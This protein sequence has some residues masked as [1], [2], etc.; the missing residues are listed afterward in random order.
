MRIAAALALLFIV[1]PIARA[2]DLINADRPGIADGSAAVGRGTFQ[3]ETGIDRTRDDAA[4]P[5]LLRFGVTNSIEAR[6]E[7]DT[8]VRTHGGATEWQPV[9]LGVK[10]HFADTPSLATI[11]RIFVP[12]GS[13]SSRQSHAS[14]DVRLAC[15]FNVG[16]RW[17]FNPN[18]GIT[19]QSDGRAFLAGLAAL[20]AQFNLSERS[21][22][23]VD[24][25]AQTPEE[26][27]GAT[28]IL[29]DAGGAY[30]VG[31]NTQLDAE[32]TWRGRG[33]TAANLTLS[34]GVAHRF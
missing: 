5:T 15:D 18:V 33:R 34:A 25:G 28:S 8:L 2:D 6:I 12:S 11:V 22:V 10:W 27:G 16:D 7:S 26:K 23:F 14:G 21:N 3:F 1:A 32:A 17:S 20:T 24:A 19:E 4:L 30:V 31:R 9:S 13:G 29:L